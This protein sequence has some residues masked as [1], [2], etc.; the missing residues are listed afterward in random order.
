MRRWISRLGLPVTVLAAMSVTAGVTLAV[1]SATTPNSS[2]TITSGDVSFGSTANT[3]CVVRAGAGASGPALLPGSASTGWAT[4]GSEPPCT[5]K[6]TYSGTNA[7][8][9]GLDVLIASRAGSV[10]PGAPA[11]TNATPLFD[12]SSNGLQLRI[13]DASGATFVNGTDFT[14]QGT[15]GA[16][17]PLPSASCPAPYDISTYTCYQVNDLLVS[18]SPLTGGANDTFTLNYELPLSS[19]SSYENAAATVV[20][21]AHAVQSVNNPLPASPSA[22]ACAAGAQCQVGLPWD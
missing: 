16:P 14:T 15:A 19:P 2:A 12:D 21:T 10:A 8:Y 11:G 20:L 17:T 22:G 3:T 6:V 1:L 4:P 7:A 13:S 5:L 18:T 9:L